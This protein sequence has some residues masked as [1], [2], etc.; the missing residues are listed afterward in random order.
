MKIR[1]KTHEQFNTI[2]QGL[3]RHLRVYETR[4]REKIPHPAT[5]LNQR[6][7]EGEA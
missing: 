3:H 2:M 1:P 6:R 7:W 5:W 4:E